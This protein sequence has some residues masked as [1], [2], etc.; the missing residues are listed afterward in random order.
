MRVGTGPFVFEEAKSDSTYITLVRNKR[1][2]EKDTMGKRLPYLDSLV[3]KV[4]SSKTD[5]IFAFES[6]G[7]D[8]VDNLPSDKVSEI[9]SKNITKFKGDRAHY[10][11]DRIPEMSTEI[12]IFNTKQPPFDNV[13][14]RQAFSYAIDRD[15]IVNEVLKGEQFV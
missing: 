3:V 8:I 4:L 7:L 5:E 12:Y 2:H 1:Y 13:K 9:L 11:L 10:I 15:K 6:G 14:V